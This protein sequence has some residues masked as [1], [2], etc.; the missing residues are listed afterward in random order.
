MLHGNREASANNPILEYQTTQLV[1]T[2]M[3]AQFYWDRLPFLSI[4]TAV[5]LRLS[6]CCIEV[7]QMLYLGRKGA[8]SFPSKAQRRL[9]F[10]SLFAKAVPSW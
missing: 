9:A 1:T 2:K 8:T 3:S 6:R 4:L 7:A 10:G 5:A